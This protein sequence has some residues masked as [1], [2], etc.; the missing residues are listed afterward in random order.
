ME[1][2][3][4]IGSEIVLP[5]LCTHHVHHSLSVGWCSL[6][7]GQQTAAVILDSL[8]KPYCTNTKHQNLLNTSN[9]SHEHKLDLSGQEQVEMLSLYVAVV[10]NECVWMNAT[11][12][13]TAKCMHVYRSRAHFMSVC[14]HTCIHLFRLCCLGVCMSTA[15][16]G[17]LLVFFG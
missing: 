17:T 2:L 4:F 13:C 1:D 10:G 16:V 12:F 3:C 15:A 6:S 14:A 7:T 11:V 5:E 9:C 8:T